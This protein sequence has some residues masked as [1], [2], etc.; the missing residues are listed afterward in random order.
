MKPGSREGKVEVP[1]PQKTR[2]CAEFYPDS[3]T[4]LLGGCNQIVDKL[5]HIWSFYVSCLHPTDFG[6]SVKAT[7]CQANKELWCVSER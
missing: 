4:L 1:C 3:E 2:D 6:W 7:V 5:V